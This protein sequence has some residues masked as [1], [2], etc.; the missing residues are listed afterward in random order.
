MGNNKP[1]LWTA[2]LTAAGTGSA[3]AQITGTPTAG[4]FYFKNVESGKFLGA[5]NAWGTQASLTDHGIVIKTA[6][7]DGKYTL[8]TNTFNNEKHFFDGLYMDAASKEI[9]IAELTDQPGKYVMKVDGN[10]VVTE[11]TVVKTG[12]TDASKAAVWQIVPVDDLKK[13]FAKATFSAPADATFLIKGA[14]ISRGHKENES[15]LGGGTIGGAQ[16]NFVCEKVGGFDIYQQIDNVPT[17][18]YRLK[19]QGYYRNRCSWDHNGSYEGG[20][21]VVKSYVYANG[22]SVK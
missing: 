4:D 22:S 8:D 7:A 21:E 19:V 1:L 15:W 3:M 6:L 9:E 14:G 20:S 5:G 10:Y 12:D 17:G 16:T 11:G 2:I 13:T 18:L